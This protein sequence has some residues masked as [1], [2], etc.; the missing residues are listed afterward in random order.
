MKGVNHISVLS[1]CHIR[2]KDSAIPGK[3]INIEI[4][5]AGEGSA[6]SGVP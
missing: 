5:Y 4:Y 6:E 3:T 1:D 2:I